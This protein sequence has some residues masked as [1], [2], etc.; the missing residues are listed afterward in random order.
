MLERI[1]SVLGDPAAIITSWEKG[2]LLSITS[3]VE[4][5]AELTD[6]QVK[7]LERIEQKNSSKEKEKREQW[8]R[9]WTSEKSEIA[10]VVAKY[11]SVTGY[12][13]FLTHKILEEGYVPTEKE[14]TKM[15]ENKY[16]LKVRE[17]YFKKP[18]Y[19]AGVVVQVRKTHTANK[20]MRHLNGDV[21]V[22]ISDMYAVVLEANAVEPFRAAAGAKVYK[23]LPFGSPK[24]Y[25][26]SE[27]D[28]KKARG[29]K[30]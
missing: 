19:D 11:Y 12:F 6:P 22:K 14:Y 7:V 20:H 2:F 15:C 24:A 23:I 28:I 5:G 13:S 25:Y 18:D 9:D 21:Y 30:K 17:A 29:I 10:R 3:Q 27:S 26:V 4:S 16:A 1:S 8:I